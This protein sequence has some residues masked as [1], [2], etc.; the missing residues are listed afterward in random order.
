MRTTTRRTPTR[1]TPLLSGL[2]LAALSLGSTGCAH[3]L[4]PLPAGPDLRGWTQ[5]VDWKSAEQEIAG[6]LSG[7]LQVDTMNPPG[8]ETRGARY[9]AALL[10][11]EG[12]P[13]RI[14]EHAPG[15][16]SLIARLEGSGKKK[17]FCLLSHIDVV[18]AKAKEWPKG[19]GPLSGTIDAE[20]YVWGRGALDMKGM[21]ALEIMTMIWLKRLKVPLD[22][23]VVLLA[24]ADEEVD[25]Q[26]MKHVVARHWKEIGCSHLINEG[27][28]GVKDLLTKGQSV[29]AISVAEKSVLWVKMT[30]RGRG[31]HGSTPVPGSTPERLLEALRKIMARKPKPTIDPALTELLARAGEQQGGFSGFVLKRPA[32]VRVFVR[33]KLMKNPVTRAAITNTVNLTNIDTGRNEPNVVPS[34]AHAIF[35]CRLLPGTKPASILAEL[36]ERVG[37][38]PGISFEVLSNE[39][40]GYS[41]WN[42]PLFFALSRQLRQGRKD[43]AVGPALSVGFSDSIYARRVGVRAYGMVPFEVPKEELATMHGPNERVSLRNLREGLR[44]L[45]AVTLEISTD[46]AKLPPPPRVAAKAKPFARVS[47]AELAAIRTAA[48]PTSR[49]QASQPTSRP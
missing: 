36:R 42:D 7:Y 16:G 18:P 30:V 48:P 32:L 2:L 21:G 37:D 33:G 24:V 1:Q 26:G 27:S 29:F 35:D 4:T 9:L 19:K 14:V 39:P 23:D 43:V 22:R 44:I 11:R 12:I 25:N 10:A 46:A 45:F 34:S 6:V 8:N 49:P 28:I 31:G 17:P 47:A 3:P 20:G 40:S 15:R 38:D 5:A 13:S 41:S